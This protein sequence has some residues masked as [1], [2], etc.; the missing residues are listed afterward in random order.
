[1]PF[2]SATGIYDIQSVS[3]AVRWQRK[4]FPK[5]S[6]SD[7]H[8]WRSDLT[9]SQRHHGNPDRGNSYNSQQYLR[10]VTTLDMPNLLVRLHFTNGQSNGN[11][12]QNI[13]DNIQ[14]NGTVVPEPA[15]VAGGLL[16]VLGLCWFQRRRLNCFCRVRGALSATSFAGEHSASRVLVSASAETIFNVR[17][18]VCSEV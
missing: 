12:I 7:E 18:P 3:F 13:I 8:Q 15:T 11:N 6:A 9:Q 17:Q 4:W 10:T 1:M 16:G 2:N 5:C 14:I